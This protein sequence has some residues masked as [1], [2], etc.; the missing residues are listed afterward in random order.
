MVIF[1]DNIVH[2]TRPGSFFSFRNSLGISSTWW[3]FL[4]LVGISS[5]ANFPTSQSIS[6][7]HSFHPDRHSFLPFKTKRKPFM[8]F[9]EVVKN[10]NV[11]FSVSLT[12]R[13]DPPPSYGQQNF[14]KI[15]TSYYECIWPETDFGKKNFFTIFDHF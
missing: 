8:F 6:L 13:V 12:V 1:P 4:L 11:L 5:V 15:K 2:P 9:R 14:K 7:Q 3:K 10:K